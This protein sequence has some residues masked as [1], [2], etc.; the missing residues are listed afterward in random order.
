MNVCIY[1]Y[2][3]TYVLTQDYYVDMHTFVYM[4]ICTYRYMYICQI[5][6]QKW[7]HRGCLDKWRTTREDKVLHVLSICFIN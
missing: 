1:V 3:C 4:Y 7:V 6:T 2:M 5:G